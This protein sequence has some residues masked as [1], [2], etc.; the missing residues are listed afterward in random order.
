M[1][2]IILLFVF[3]LLYVIPANCQDVIE[4]KYEN[5]VYTLPCA[6]NG[7]NLNFIFDTGAAV[8]SISSAEA[9]FMLKNGYLS[10]RDF[11]DSEQYITADGSI[12][13][14][15]VFNIKEFKIGQIIINDVRATVINSVDAPLLLGQS[16]ISQLGKWYI[17]SN[18]LYLGVEP[19]EE[20]SNLSEEEHYKLA[21]E[22]ENKGNL[23][24][25][26]KHLEAICKDGKY[27]KE[28]VNFVL[29]NQYEKGYELASKLCL[30]MCLSGDKFM[31]YRMYYGHWQLKPK[32]KK[33]RLEFYR[34][35]SESCSPIFYGYL[36]DAY[37]ACSEPAIATEYISYLENAAFQIESYMASSTDLI[38]SNEELKERVAHIY[39]TLGGVYYEKYRQFKDLYEPVFDKEKAFKYYEKAAQLSVHGMYNY[40]FELYWD[41]NATDDTKSKGIYWLTKAAEA[42]YFDA[43]TV[44]IDAYYDGD[45]IPENYDKAIEYCNQL[46]KYND[47]YYNFNANMY[48]GRIYYDKEDFD[49]AFK[50]LN[51]ACE[52]IDRQK[53][54]K[55]FWE[56]RSGTYTLLG[57]CYYF[58]LG[59]S[60]N[61]VKAYGLYLEELEHNKED[62]YCIY[63]IAYMA[64]RGLGVQQNEKLA[65]E[66]FQ[67][68]ANRGHASCQA[69]LAWCYYAKLGTSEDISKAIFWGKKAVENNN[70]LA[71]AH[72]LLGYIYESKYHY[73]YDISKAIS[74]F[75]AAS[76][77]GS[78]AASY[79]LGIIYEYGVESSVQRNYKLAKKYYSL[80]VEQGYSKAQEKLILFE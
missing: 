38:I 60:V 41:D 16:A 65:F 64:Q 74:H 66:L 46:L 59:T 10:E 39:E 33:E 2:R 72:L 75:E 25:A 77:N 61:Y 44:L 73:N 32:N 45:R 50:H 70:T 1:I 23:E 51:D 56:Y 35:L 49:K 69:E 26:Y 15:A 34:L 43:M 71:D 48:L 80:A 30:D 11:I 42:N 6:V 20:F 31:I 27:N 22:Y 47:D 79:R 18:Y 53:Q 62:L 12:I 21:I 55:G 78:G 68:G 29:N 14:N 4:L 58:G 28:L 52:Y 13:E 8:T 19:T 57:D 36:A 37:Y 54:N 17:D 7:L 9:L 24:E 5:G 67:E 76:T 3:T 63:S 40:G